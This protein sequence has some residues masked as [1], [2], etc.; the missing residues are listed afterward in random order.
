MN[1]YFTAARSSLT[2]A[3]FTFVTPGVQVD[4]FSAPDVDVSDHLPMLMTVTF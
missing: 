1:T 4:T 3:A 2:C